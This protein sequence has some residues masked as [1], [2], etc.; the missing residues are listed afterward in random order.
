MFGDT[1]KN[2]NNKELIK[3]PGIRGYGRKSLARLSPVLKVSPWSSYYCFRIDLL[4]PPGPGHETPQ[5]LIFTDKAFFTPDGIYYFGFIVPPFQVC[6][7]LAVPILTVVTR[8]HVAV[9]RVTCP[10]TPAAW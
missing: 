9:T 10:V 7:W 2:V 5:Y 6:E 4:F 8:A 3:S 1:E